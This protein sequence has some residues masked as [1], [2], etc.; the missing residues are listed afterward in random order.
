[1]NVDFE[2]YAIHAA[3]RGNEQAWRQLFEQHFDAVYRFCVALAD[4]RHGRGAG[5][6]GLHHCS[7]AG[8]SFRSQPGDLSSMAVRD[9]EE[10]LYDNAGQ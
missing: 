3:Q 9:R 7:P 2:T 10:P 5:P 4:G 8:T 6:A 1:M